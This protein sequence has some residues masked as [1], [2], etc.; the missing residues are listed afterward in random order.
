MLGSNRHSATTVAIGAMA[1]SL[2][3]PPRIQQA[4]AQ[5]EPTSPLVTSLDGRVTNSTVD[6]FERLVEFDYLQPEA[7]SGPASDAFNKVVRE[8]FPKFFASP[9]AY[10]GITDTRALYDRFERDVLLGN[11]DRVVPHPL[12]NITEVL[13]SA[14]VEGGCDALLSFRV[15][16]LFAFD[17][18]VQGREE[19]LFGILEGLLTKGSSSGFSSLLELCLYSNNEAYSK[20]AAAILS[21][22]VGGAEEFFKR[23][24]EHALA[25]RAGM[26]LQQ[27]DPFLKTGLRLEQSLNSMSRTLNGVEESLRPLREEA[28]R[29]RSEAEFQEVQREIKEEKA[30]YVRRQE[31][32]VGGIHKTE[33]WGIDKGT[34]NEDRIPIGARIKKVRIF[35]EENQGIRGI[36]MVY[37]KNGREGTT[38][39]RGAA[40]GKEAVFDVGEYEYI[41]S[42]RGGVRIRG[43]LVFIRLRKYSLLTRDPAE[44]ERVSDLPAVHNVLFIEPALKAD[45]NVEFAVAD[46][47]GNVAIGLR[48]YST[49][50]NLWGVGLIC[51]AGVPPYYQLDKNDFMGRQAPVRHPKPLGLSDAWFGGATPNV[52]RASAAE[53]LAKPLAAQHLAVWGRRQEF[54]PS[55]PEGAEKVFQDPAVLR[56]CPALK[57]AP[58]LEA[59]YRL[60]EGECL[61]RQPLGD[62]SMKIVGA[63]SE[64]ATNAGQDAELAAKIV[65]LL[66]APSRA[67]DSDKFLIHVLHE[68][69]RRGSEGAQ[70]AICQLIA[71]D[72]LPTNL[73]PLIRGPHKPVPYSDSF[74]SFIEQVRAGRILQSRESLVGALTRSKE[75]ARRFEEQLSTRE[76]ELEALRA[77]LK[78]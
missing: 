76:K 4:S 42:I 3:C 11:D 74:E 28:A 65:A 54:K 48:T 23:Y 71:Y 51:Q 17:H 38:P 44:G 12:L 25:T 24:P 40:R 43:D 1:L 61:E 36:Q 29:R 72:P 63:L 14:A 22:H 20:R 73:D 35:W 27:S 68:L 55:D 26:L 58:S 59:K 49:K 56:F 19:V 32:P 8:D 57:D 7:P 67:H 39:L 41:H 21:Q 10:A 31:V 30:D 6:F 9:E 16:C 62:S 34:L 37:D 70:I 33:V 18:N 60:L 53:T 66:A 13:T 75:A 45:S 46:P 77:E 64:V 69:R 78:K 2:L 5:S 15:K 52:Q 50:D 47:D